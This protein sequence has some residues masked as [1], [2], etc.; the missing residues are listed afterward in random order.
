MVLL[1]KWTIISKW[2]LFDKFT[3]MITKPVYTFL[4]QLISQRRKLDLWALYFHQKPIK[5]L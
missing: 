4:N 5:D 1:M 2:H 3:L